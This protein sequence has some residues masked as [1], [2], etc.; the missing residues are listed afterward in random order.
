MISV[1][2]KIVYLFSRS[3][4]SNSLWP[5]RQQPTRLPCPLPSPRACSNSCMKLNFYLKKKADYLP[6][7]Y[8]HFFYLMELEILGSCSRVLEIRVYKWMTIRSPCYVMHTLQI[9]NVLRYLWERWWKLFMEMELWGYHFL[10]RAV[11]LQDLLHPYQ[12]TSW[13]HWRFMPKWGIFF[14]FVWFYVRELISV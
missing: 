8:S 13:I 1:G 12:W 9:Q 5:S 6:G 3:V 11:W 2:I 7:I 10:E 4:T 14:S